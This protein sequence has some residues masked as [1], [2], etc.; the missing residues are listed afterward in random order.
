MEVVIG[1]KGLGNSWQN[2]FSPT[3]TCECGG[4]ARIAFVAMENSRE[5]DFVADLHE[6]EGKGGFWPHDAIAVAVYF[7]KECLNPVAVFNQA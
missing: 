2:E 7:C 5:G 4:K 1:E 3:A 6:N